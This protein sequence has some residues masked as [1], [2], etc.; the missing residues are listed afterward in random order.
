MVNTAVSAGICRLLG[1]QV[2]VGGVYHF[3][4]SSGSYTTNMSEKSVSCLSL[5]RV[6]KFHDSVING[7]MWQTL[8]YETSVERV[9]KTDG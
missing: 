6:G 7:R 5:R 9:G 1:V 8:S 2:Q 4:F 3:R